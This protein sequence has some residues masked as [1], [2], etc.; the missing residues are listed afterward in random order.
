M[1]SDTIRTWSNSTRRTS[2]NLN[3]SRATHLELLF[4]ASTALSHTSL[5]LP[6]CIVAHVNIVV[7]INIS[8]SGDGAQSRKNE[9]EQ[10]LLLPLLFV[11]ARC[12]IPAPRGLSMR[13]TWDTRL[14]DENASSG[15]S[16]PPTSLLIPSHSTKNRPG[17][18]FNLLILK[19]LMTTISGA[20]EPYDICNC[21][22]LSFAFSRLPFRF[23]LVFPARIS[24]CPC[25][26]SLLSSLRIIFAT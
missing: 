1:L 26:A 9:R 7:H 14:V 12:A 3:P 4:S 21:M 15:R 2:A 8:T 23:R 24:L 11:F 17:R 13:S 10:W 19:S 6:W 16:A 20:H 22:N 5:L 18:L 25:F